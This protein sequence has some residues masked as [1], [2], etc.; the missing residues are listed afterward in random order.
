[1]QIVDCLHSFNVYKATMRQNKMKRGKKIPSKVIVNV[2]G[3]KEKRHNCRHCFV[4][5]ASFE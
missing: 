5:I 3:E 1:M 2:E 4:F